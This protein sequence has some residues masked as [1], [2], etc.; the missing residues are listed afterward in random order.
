MFSSAPR[1]RF[2]CLSDTHGR[3]KD[4]D[5]E[6]PEGDVL[7]H[8]G[9][10]TNVGEPHQVAEFNEWLGKQPHPIKIVIAGN[11]EVSFDVQNYKE[12][13]PK[14]HKKFP[15]LDPIKTR[16]LL[17]N[18]TYLEN[19]FT[20]V[21]GYKVYGSP[22]SPELCGWAFNAERGKEIA[23]IWEKIP[24]DTDILIT[25]GPPYGILDFDEMLDRKEGCEDLLKAVRDRVKP[26]YHV[27]G[28][29]HEGHG[30]LKKHGTTFVN[31]STCDISYVPNQR[32]IVFELPVK[33]EESL[34]DRVK[35]F[36][37]KY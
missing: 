37:G 17:T 25:H 6:V 12:L 8:S 34:L 21:H 23:D 35:M 4:F 22:W 14:F 13:A 15:D 3:T 7:I 11:H 36:F 33:G 32:P 24:T 31:A 9:D 2:V 20:E 10:F 5:F 27:F 26:L 29:I 1:I 19:S 30:V 28:H 18:C 16:A